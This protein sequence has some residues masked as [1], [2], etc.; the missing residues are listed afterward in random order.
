M[1]KLDLLRAPWC[2]SW[3]M[4]LREAATGKDPGAV[5]ST[6]VQTIAPFSAAAS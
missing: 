2:P 5:S 3:F 4:H 1:F 6:I